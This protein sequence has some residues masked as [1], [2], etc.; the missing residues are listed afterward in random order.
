MMHHVVDD[1]PV[2][3]RLIRARQACEQATGGQEAEAAH[4]NLRLAAEA[5]RDAE[6]SWSII[7]EALG[8]A[9][10]NAYKRYRRKPARRRGASPR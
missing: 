3:Q 1:N 10:G 5:A 8:I 7:G 9:R 4:R 2:L 6:V